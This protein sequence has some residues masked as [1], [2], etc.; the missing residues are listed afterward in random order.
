MFDV[1]SDAIMCLHVYICYITHFTCDIQYIHVQAYVCLF[2]CVA[3]YFIS[4]EKLV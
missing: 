2:S 3:L 1:I 4:D